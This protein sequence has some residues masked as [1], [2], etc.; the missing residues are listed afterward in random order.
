MERSS[1]TFLNF[2]GMQSGHHQDFQYLVVSIHF[3]RTAL[4]VSV[5]L[6]DC[7]PSVRPSVGLSFSPSVTKISQDWI[8]SFFLILYMMIDDHDI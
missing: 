5:L 1:V 8:I 6:N 7:R 4:V 2:K 3:G